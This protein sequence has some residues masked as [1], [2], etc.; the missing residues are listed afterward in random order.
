MLPPPR[1]LASDCILQTFPKP[2]EWLLILHQLMGTSHQAT[3]VLKGVQRTD[4]CWKRKES[5]ETG[6]GYHEEEWRGP[7]TRNAG[8]YHPEKHSECIR[9]LTRWDKDSLM[10]GHYQTL[11][12]IYFPP[13]LN[14][15]LQLLLMCHPLASAGTKSSHVYTR[16]HPRLG[17][18]TETGPLSAGEASKAGQGGIRSWRLIPCGHHTAH[19]LRALPN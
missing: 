15:I 16:W 5:W 9:L 13:N 19:I 11:A 17:T 7:S 8:S 10:F 2:T 3:S 14:E 4:I 12:F 18:V 1:M 6:V